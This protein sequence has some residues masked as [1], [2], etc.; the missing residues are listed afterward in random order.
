M[1]KTANQLKYKFGLFLLSKLYLALIQAF[2][3]HL[4][5]VCFQFHLTLYKSRKFKQGR[6][7]ATKASA[8]YD[9]ILTRDK[10]ALLKSL[11]FQCRYYTS[12]RRGLTG[13]AYPSLGAMRE[14]E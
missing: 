3:F 4:V 10:P 8:L 13:V 6:L 11:F 9:Y 7:T 5:G 14:P 12:Y 1:Q 2:I